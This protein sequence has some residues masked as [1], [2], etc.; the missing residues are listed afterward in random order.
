MLKLFEGYPV[1]G[2][3]VG[4]SWASVWVPCPAVLSSLPCYPFHPIKT[5]GG[6]AMREGFVLY[7]FDPNREVSVPIARVIMLSEDYQFFQRL[8]DKRLNANGFLMLV[9]LEYVRKY[10]PDLLAPYGDGWEFFLN[11]EGVAV[12]RGVNLDSLPVVDMS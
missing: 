7:A 10:Y 8:W 5:I 11:A 3:P 1:F 9:V 2:H 4:C 12:Y 6:F